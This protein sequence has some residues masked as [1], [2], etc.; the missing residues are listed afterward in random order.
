MVAFL[1]ELN[2]HLMKSLLIILPSLIVGT[3]VNAQRGQVHG[4][5]WDDGNSSPI[6]N[7]LRVLIVF[8]AIVWI[9]KWVSDKREEKQREKKKLSKRIISESATRKNET[10]KVSQRA[11]NDV[12]NTTNPNQ[13]NNRYA[14]QEEYKNDFPKND[15]EESTKNKA[16]VLDIKKVIEYLEKQENRKID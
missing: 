6:G 4:S 15:E 13:K 5:D 7:L 1:N 14:I 11:G 9:V 16:V 10:E 12:F 3:A 8:G 2:Q